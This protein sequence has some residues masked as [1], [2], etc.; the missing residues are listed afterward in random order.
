MFMEILS[1][2]ILGEQDSVR[3]IRMELAAPSIAAKAC[4][5]QF[6]VLMVEEKG[7]RIPLTIVEQ[8]IQKGSITIIFQEVGLTTRLLG[9]FNP[10][11]S[12]A[13]L[14]GPLGRPTDARNYGKALIIGGGVGI[15]EIYPVA[16]ALKKKNNRII[17]I[18]GAR[19]ANLLILEQE[20]KKISDEIYIVSDDGSAGKKCFTTDILQE[21]LSIR[22]FAKDCGLVYCV[23]PV[24][25][26]KKTALITKEKNLNT[27]ASLNALMLDATG[28]CG[29][30]RVTVAGEVKFSCIDGPEFDAHL[31]D[32]DEL[33]R[34]NRVYR[35]KE[36][37][38]CNLYN[39]C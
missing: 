27:R 3:I 9:K 34:R 18:L 19:T 8:D 25:M 38:I 39:L 7:E 4:A 35:D 13:V 6:I 26:M 5:G 23:G 33:E 24:P 1:K 22:E 29:V 20:L 17:T 32:W 28:M 30:C 21:L 12:L 11:D 10:G 37:H 31:V 36:K 16:G 2:K 15:A 14:T